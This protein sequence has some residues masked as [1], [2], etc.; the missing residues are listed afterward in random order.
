MARDSTDRAV[1]SRYRF[2]DPPWRIRDRF[3]RI[4]PM[5]EVDFAEDIL[6]RLRE[7]HPRFHGK[8]YLFILSALHEVMESMD[9]RRH[10]SGGELSEGVRTLAIEE[11]GPM[12]RTVLEHWGIHSTQDLG[13]IVFALVDAGVLVKEEQDRLEDF[14]DI[15]DFEEAFDRN[16]PWTTGI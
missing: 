10:I 12:A 6:D 3:P 11:F 9:H 4:P 15:F 5:T 14:R 8:A 1:R 2:R 16:Y 13:E 7:R